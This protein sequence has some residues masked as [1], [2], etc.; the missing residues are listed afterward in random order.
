MESTP[1]CM[2]GSPNTKFMLKFSQISLE[3]VKVYTSLYS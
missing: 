1:F 3:R 2:R